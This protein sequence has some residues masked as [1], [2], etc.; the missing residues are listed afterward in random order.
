MDKPWIVSIQAAASSKWVYVLIAAP[1]W[2]P[3]LILLW[4]GWR[5]Y[6]GYQC[7]HILAGVYGHQ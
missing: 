5:F 3:K 4:I 6:D 2:S 7:L 1:N